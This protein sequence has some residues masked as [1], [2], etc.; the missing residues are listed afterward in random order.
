MRQTPAEIYFCS[1]TMKYKFSANLT[2]LP[3]FVIISSSSHV[4]ATLMKE[5]T[6]YPNAHANSGF[7]PFL[8]SGPLRPMIICLLPPQHP[9]FNSLNSKPAKYFLF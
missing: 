3:I 5:I 6:S 9:P 2:T 4:I 7:K 1:L 8:Q